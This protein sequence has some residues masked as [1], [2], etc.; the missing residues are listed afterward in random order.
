M[1]IRRTINNFNEKALAW[2]ERRLVEENVRNFLKNDLSAT[3][4]EGL[5][6]Y[7]LV[8]SEVKIDSNLPRSINLVLP[9]IS[10]KGI[11]AGIR[12]AVDVAVR[13]A[14]STDS[15]LRIISFRGPLSSAD[16]AAVKN[17]ISA[18]FSMPD[19]LVTIVSPVSLPSLRVRNEDIWVATYWTTAHALDISARLNRIDR[20]RVMYLIQDYEPS[21]LPAST[22]S[23][24]ASSTYHAGFVPLVN[25]MP[26]YET[27][28]RVE[29]LDLQ[30]ADVF[31]PQLDLCRLHEAA[32]L[33]KNGP[34]LR[35][36]L[37]YGRPDK[38]RNMFNLGI[39]SLRRAASI[40][41]TDTAWRFASAG[42]DLPRISLGSTRSL[43]PLGRL[44][45]N[46]YF[47]VLSQ[48][49][50]L[51]SLQ[52]S[53]HPSHP[54]LDMVVSGG[55]AVTNELGETRESLHERLLAVRG[56]PDILGRT[57]AEE[58]LRLDGQEIVP[59]YDERFVRQ[60]GKPIYLAIDSAL[61]KI[62]SES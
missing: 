57:I 49:R 42:Q 46:E 53:P 39:A 32:N 61:R 23:F 36:V 62:A 37:F 51:L 50:L 27:L 11:F 2:N 9:A 34:Q 3:H 60:L 20:S 44:S 5:N 18:E 47:H 43:E 31:A 6:P 19:E 16:G 10:A 55:I 26:L 7:S 54:P 15:H 40:L 41:P 48:T 45:W 4:Y 12:T 56:D 58:L 38:P 21:F 52:A 35:H 59:D 8:L 14:K 29:S 33:R 22:E 24:L 25:S 1:I 30:P 13:L 28:R 17:L